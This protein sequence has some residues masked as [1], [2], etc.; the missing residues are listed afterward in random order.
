VAHG[1]PD[2]SNVVKSG[3]PHRLDDLAELAVRLS[4]PNLFDRRGEVL[5]ATAFS[6]GL[7]AVT[8]GAAGTGAAVDLFAGNSRQGAFCTRLTAGSDGAR[9][10]QI[11]KTLALPAACQVGLELTIS[12]E[13]NT[14]YW[15]VRLLWYD[16]ATSHIG[17]IHVHHAS[18][19]LQYYSSGGVYTTFASGVNLVEL[20]SPTH[21]LKM[22]LD[23]EEDTYVRCILNQTTYDLSAY[24]LFTQAAATY[25]HLEALI[26]HY[27]TAGNNPV[28]YLDNVI[29]TQNEP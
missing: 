10:A 20:S 12:V 16:G 9:Y 1:A 18:H 6:E 3:P 24:S 26:A 13:A 28:A 2:D 22:V 14:D 23:M 27:A 21:T 17:T 7:G 15:K 11:Y 8:T 25:P 29:V 4:S 5:F 19:V